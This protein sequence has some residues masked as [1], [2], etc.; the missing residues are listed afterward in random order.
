[1]RQTS[2]NCVYELAKKDNRVVFIGSDLGANV[3][4]SFKNEFPERFF[5]EGISEQHIVGMAA[6]MALNGFIPYINTIATFLTRRCFEQNFIDLGLHNTNV[7]LIASGGGLVYAPL[8]PTHLAIEDIAIMR[9]IPNMTIICP[10]DA[11]EMKFIMPQTLDHKGPIYIRLA[12]GYDPIVTDKFQNFKIG[13]ATKISEG[14]DILLISTGITLQICLE[15][16]NS[17]KEKNISCTILHCSTLKPFDKESLLKESVNH[18]Y[19]FTVEEHSI[20]GG[21]GSIC[22]EILM[23]SRLINNKFFKRFAIQ[24]HFPYGYGSQAEMM[25]RENISSDKIYSQ[26]VNLLKV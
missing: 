10:S 22:S 14:K 20:I 8:G 1:M 5:M 26:I 24:D 21:L 16:M 7:R 17:L 3:L 19:I 25:D 11:N 15:I 2:L 18:E 12:K 6:G 4:D 23:E 9:T 13:K